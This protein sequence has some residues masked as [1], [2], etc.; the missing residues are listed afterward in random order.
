MI[1]VYVL[2][3]LRDEVWYPGIAKDAENR[4]HEH[5]TGKNRFTKGHQ[6]WNIIY[7]ED[8]PDWGSAPLVFYPFIL[9]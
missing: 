6:P 7:T 8:H 2:E 9:W 1:S 4:L 5:N 3:S